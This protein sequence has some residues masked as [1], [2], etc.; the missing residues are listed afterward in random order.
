VQVAINAMEEAA[1]RALVAEL[2]TEE[3][4]DALAL[5][6][7]VLGAAKDALAQEYVRLAADASAPAIDVGALFGRAAG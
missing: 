2:P 6:A 3:L 5:V 4:A 7:T 1:W